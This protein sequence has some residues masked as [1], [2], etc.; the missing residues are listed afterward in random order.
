MRHKIIGD[1]FYGTNDTETR[2][3]AKTN[4]TYERVFSI[5]ETFVRHTRINVVFEGL[6][7][8]ATILINGVEIGRSENMFRRYIF[9]VKKALRVG[10]A[11]H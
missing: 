6:D 8:F 9:D 10:E 4:W 3:V 5:D 7:T 11:T 2:W 1:V